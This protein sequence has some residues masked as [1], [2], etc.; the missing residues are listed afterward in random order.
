VSS[1]PVSVVI[2]T[3]NEEANIVACL[4][5]C[6]WCD[7]VHV[8][9]S[10]ST[11]RTIELAR[12]N[13]AAVHVHPFKAFGDQRNWAID[14]IATRH[15]WIFH[16]DA[17][18]RFTPQLVAAVAS[19]VGGGPLEP[20]FYVPEKL[21][22]MGRW[23]KRAAGYPKYQMRLFHKARTRFRDYGHGQ[24]ELTDGA[25]GM[26]DEPYLHLAFSKGLDDW[27]HKHNRYS[28]LEAQ[29]AYAASWQRLPV[30]W[31]ATREPVRRR[32][33]W[34]ELAYHLPMRPF[35]RWFVTLFI[36]GGMFEGRA[37]WT[38]ARLIALYEEMITLKLRLLRA[39]S[40]GAI[41]RR[42]VLDQHR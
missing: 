9:D 35:A 32:R 36:R 3:L 19:I 5:S 40:N 2:L 13:G 39:P 20:G 28:S 38:Y 31:L 12:Q 6:S 10:G 26:L 11:D 42:N 17:D 33:A 27:I 4:A 15:E 30:V 8:L 23:L 22:F 14:H 18:E 7:D 41:Q 21:I 25:V 24:R 34:K 1:A 16:L 37:G 29:Q